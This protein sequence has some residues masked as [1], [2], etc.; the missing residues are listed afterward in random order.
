MIMRKKSGTRKP[1]ILCPIVI[2]IRTTKTTDDEISRFTSFGVSWSFNASSS[3]VSFALA[4]ISR[5]SDSLGA[6][7]YP[8]ASTAFMTSLDASTYK[9]R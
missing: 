7:P 6:A 3:S 2:Y 8:A 1:H 9:P 5:A 4:L